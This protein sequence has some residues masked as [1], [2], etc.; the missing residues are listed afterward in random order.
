MEA[1]ITHLLQKAIAFLN[2][3]CSVPEE[4]GPLLSRGATEPKGGKGSSEIS[5]VADG[6][7]ASILLN[8]MCP[9][10]EPKAPG[11]CELSSAVLDIRAVLVLY[12]C[13]ALF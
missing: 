12:M 7:E 8:S 4:Q 1:A 11:S 3:L 6:P 2:A 9:S 5:S 10:E 13:L